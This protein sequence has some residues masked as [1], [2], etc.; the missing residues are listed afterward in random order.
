MLY[1]YHFSIGDQDSFF[2][3]CENWWGANNRANVIDQL[4]DI[5]GYSC[6]YSRDDCFQS[7]FNQAGYYVIPGKGHTF[8]DVHPDSEFMNQSTPWGLSANFDWLAEQGR[9]P[10]PSGVCSSNSGTTAGNRCSE[11]SDC[12]CGR[13]GLHASDNANEDA[14]LTLATA[15][16]DHRGLA[17]GDNGGGGGGKPNPPSP[18]PPVTPLLTAT[19]APPTNAPSSEPC[20]CLL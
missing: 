11:S 19:S 16:S 6:E 12:E 3:A 20:G 14:F 4:R 1:V 13:R 9:V 18:T 7:N 10:S 15:D 8:M 5:S 2:G 17:K